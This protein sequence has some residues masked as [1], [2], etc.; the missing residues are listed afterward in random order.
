VGDFRCL[1]H[2][3]NIDKK[4]P[5]LELYKLYMQQEYQNEY[6]S[7]KK[8]REVADEFSGAHQWFPETREM[9]PRRIIYHMGPTNSGKTKN[10]LDALMTAKNGLY[11]APL[12]LLALEIH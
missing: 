11:C 2:V 9:P 10:A 7:A 3:D 4:I 12:R 5:Y 8:M 1:S 6:Y